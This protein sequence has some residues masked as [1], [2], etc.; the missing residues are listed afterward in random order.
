VNTSPSLRTSRRSA[1]GFSL[2]ELIVGVA[3]SLIGILVMFRM[4]SLWDLHSRTT[5]S[6]GDAQVTGTL[7]IYALER[8]L[9]PAG[10]GFGQAAPPAMGCNVLANDLV[11]PRPFNFP[12]Q[13][14]NIQV[15]AGAIP[16]QITIFYGDSSFY[17]S[18]EP[19]QGATAVS[20]TLRRR[21]GFRPGD[22]AIVAGNPGAGF[23]SANCALVEITGAANPDN[24][25]VDHGVANYLSFYTGALKGVRYN[26]VAG[27]GAGFATGMMYSLGPNPQVAQWQITTRPNGTRALS[28]TELIF[29]SPQL[30]VAENVINLKAQYGVDADNNGRITNALPNEWTTVAPADFTQV[31]AIR[32]AVL[33]RSRQFERSADGSAA[34]PTG[35]TQIA[36]SWAAGNFVMTNLDGTADAFGG[37]PN[38]PDPNNWRFYRYR[39]YEKVIPLRNMIWGTSP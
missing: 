20:K 25:T 39:V 35:I 10:M 17:V 21:G 5:T 1:R 16:D 34:A 24:R 28:R 8:D 30:D 37:A 19:L 33:V 4:V 38:T 6:G 14:V 13:P 12:L 18:Q 23:G 9:K 31:L 3:I 29:N 15:N 32:V 11:G 27:V 36:P 2:V 22:L 26:T 7:A